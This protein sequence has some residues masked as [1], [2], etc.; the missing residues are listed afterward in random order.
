MPMLN[1]ALRSA[2]RIVGVEALPLW[3]V[4]SFAKD[5]VRADHLRELFALKDVDCV[6]DV[7]AF[8]GHFGRFLRQ[9]VGFRGRIISFE[10]QPDSFRLLEQAARADDMWTVNNLALGSHGGEL[11]MNL[12]SKP[13]FSSFLTPNISATPQVFAGRNAVVGKARVRIETLDG[14]Y[15][16]MARTLGFQRP[17]LKMDTQ[18]YDLN[19][20][21]GAS[22]CLSKIVGL[23]SEVS[24]IPLYDGMPTWLD[25]INTYSSNGF[26]LSGLYEVSRSE[27]QHVVEFDAVFVRQ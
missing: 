12:M 26:A 14:I 18:G 9:E 23:Q 11:E 10:P 5:R 20:F 7:G 16:A 1:K 27:L 21:Q 25:A 4:S 2:L 3:Q 8:N 24:V 13:W 17:F 22:A 6:F 19:V 15:D